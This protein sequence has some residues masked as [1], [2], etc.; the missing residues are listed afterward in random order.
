[1]LN[2]RHPNTAYDRVETDDVAKEDVEAAPRPAARAT[3]KSAPWWYVSVPLV[4]SLWSVALAWGE[5]GSSWHAISSCSW[6]HGDPREY[7]L[8][9]VANIQLT[10]FYSRGLSKD[11][12]TLGIAEFYSDMYM[13]R[14]FQRL[15]R[16]PEPPNGAYIMGDIFDGGRV[17]SPAEHDQHRDR[18]D[19]IFGG[20]RRLQFWNMSGN[21]DVG[22]DEWTSSDANKMHTET[23]GPTTEQIVLGHIELVV[24]D[25]AALLSNDQKRYEAA[26]EFITEYGNSK[27]KRFYPRILL[28]HVPLYR[29]AGSD[30]GS[31][32][33]RHP[34]APETGESYQ[35]M[36]PAKLSAKILD[37][38]EPVHVFSTDD[39]AP[40]TYRHPEFQNV[41]EDTLATF[42]WMLGERNPEITLVTLPGE[43]LS[44]GLP[45]H[46]NTCILPD[47]LAIFH[48]YAWLAVV[49]AVYV[50]WGTLPPTLKPSVVTYGGIVLPIVVFYVVL[51]QFSLV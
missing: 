26:L 51:L 19:R 43:P 23:F 44:K 30:C 22:I 6:A 50:G 40:C 27:K 14:H 10:D 33:P 49:T 20:H 2:L 15:A 39:V 24:I 31:R 7:H 18:F 34:H 8:A 37:A 13:R 29:P 11:S 42:N 16:M 28:S 9:L 47:Q 38:V 17:L 46:V 25:A 41:Q 1:M 5:L 32:R 45:I 3:P 12:W 36:L 21:R 48:A 35:H 4:W